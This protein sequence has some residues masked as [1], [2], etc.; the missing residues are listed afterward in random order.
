VSR[1]DVTGHVEFGLNWAIIFKQSEVTCLW[2][3]D[4]KKSVVK[5]AEDET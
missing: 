5:M 1:R 3:T 4:E 2:M